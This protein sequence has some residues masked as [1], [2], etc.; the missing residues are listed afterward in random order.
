MGIYVVRAFV[1]L[2]EVLASHGAVAQKL[3]ELERK[4]QTHDCA[5]LATLKTIREL[6]SPPQPTARSIGFTAD[7]DRK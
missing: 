4:V 7:L 2:C 3:A 1:R 5:I 6:M